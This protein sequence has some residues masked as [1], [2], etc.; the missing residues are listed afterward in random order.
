MYSSDF[1]FAVNHAMLEEVGKFW[2]LTPEVAA[3]LIST[4]A[5]R[6]AVGYVNDPYDAGGETKFGI[7]QNANPEISVRNM[8]WEDAKDIYYNKYWL[9]GK[10]HLLHPRVAIL[11]FD[12]CVNHGIRNASIFLQRALGVEQ[13]GKIGPITIAAANS[14]DSQELCRRI[15][16]IRHSFYQSIVR[17]KP[18]QARFLNGWLGRID[19]VGQFV[20][21]LNIDNNA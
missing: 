14:I 6:R 16:D 1:D 12:G 17:N 8:T 11:H 4:Q 2:K 21:T 20:A 13:D 3:G 15:C 10:C 19:R 7:A 5:Q 18:S 9:A